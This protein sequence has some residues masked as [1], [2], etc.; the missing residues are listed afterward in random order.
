MRKYLFSS[1]RVLILGVLLTLLGAVPAQAANGYRE[2]SA[3]EAGSFS[4][5]FQQYKDSNWYTLLAGQSPDSGFGGQG[6]TLSGGARIVSTRLPGGGTG[7]VLNLPSGSQAVS[8]VV[9]ITSEYPTARAYVDDVKGSEGVFFY[10]SYEGT[11]T[12]E[13]PKNTGQIHGATGSWTPSSAVN[14]QPEKTTGWQP[15]RIT[16]KPGGTTSLFQVYDLYLDPRL[17]H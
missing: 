7:Q 15:V 10:V 9:C 16:L 11:K 14:L 12:W 1:P 5:P 17:S 13:A 6:W 8:P 2:T 4:Q 3:C